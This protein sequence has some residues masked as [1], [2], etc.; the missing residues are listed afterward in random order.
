MPSRSPS[1]SRSATIPRRRC[2]ATRRIGCRRPPR[3]CARTAPE[4]RRASSTQWSAWRPT[5]SRT[6]M[7]SCPT[8]SAPR[9]SR[10]T[11]RRPGSRRAADCGKRF[12]GRPSP[13]SNGARERMSTDDT[14]PK[15]TPAVARRV[16]GAAAI[17]NF[18]EWFD[19]AVYGFF[20]VT[21]GKVFFP[22]DSDT[23]SLLSSLA[24]YGVAFLVRPIGGLV[25]GAFADRHGR[26]A[27]LSLTVVLMG[28]S[29][30]LVAALPT[31]ASVGFLAPVL[32]I[33]LRCAQGFSAGG[34]WTGTSAFLVEYAPPN[35]RALWGSVVSMTA[36]L[37]T[38][39]GAVIALALS[40]W[41]TEAQL[42][43][44]GWR[45][46]FLLAAPL[47]A[48]GLYVRLRLEDTPVFRE[49]QAENAVSSRPLQESGRRNL[50]AIGLVMASASI[51][52]L[53]YYYLG[54]YV[55]T[56]LT[57][58]VGVERSTALLTV[59]GGIACYAL[60]CPV[61]G[62][63]SDRIG[64]RPSVVTGCFGLVI[65]SL[66]MLPLVATGAPGAATLGI[67][68]FG[69]FQA[70]VNVNGVVIL[71]ELFPA[72]TRV[73]SSAIGYNLGLALIAGPGPLIAAALAS[74]TDGGFPPGLYVVAVALVAGIVLI[75]GLPETR[76]RPLHAEKP[77]FRRDGTPVPARATTPATETATTPQD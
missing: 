69:I 28:V 55:I 27:A 40:T 73:S 36:A 20:A 53:G 24:V 65:V 16:A 50:R 38:L 48:I 63:L 47:G 54:S 10:A 56:Y 76:G 32:L 1:S 30:T 2:A 17:G 7:P 3:S 60:L 26:R 31:Y 44:W 58:T 6:S 8:P 39:G 4:A 77:R 5:A 35:R 70:M 15:V 9:S 29:T 14:E 18:M 22:S 52:G 12:P 59:V 46:P 42:Q 61:A 23:A 57:E 25:L 67:A 34:E 74:A 64:R 13:S 41:L 43:S 75:L 19:F 21:I 37:G 33:L 66:P 45:I 71:V 49:L 51:S 72:A 62:L 11:P 68:A